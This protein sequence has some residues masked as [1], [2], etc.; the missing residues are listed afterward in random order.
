M[1]QR[2]SATTLVQLGA[3]QPG[4]WHVNAQVVDMVRKGAAPR[5]V[6][7]TDSQRQIRFDLNKTALLVIDMQNDFCHPDGW[8]SSIGV[9]VTPARRPIKPLQALLPVMRGHQVPVLWVNWGNRPDRLNLPPAV[10]HVYNP[11]GRG[12]G[13]GDPLPGSGAPVLQAGSW[14][15]QVVDE[16][17]IEAG[18]I[19]VNKFRMSGFKDTDLD[20]ILRNLNVTTLLFA[21]VNMDQCVL[22][23]LQDANS[24]GYDCIML[25]DCCATTSPAY[26]QAAAVYNTRQCFG[27]VA[28]STEL[29]TGLS[30]SRFE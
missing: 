23:T 21:G 7:V 8:L 3:S 6:S 22:Y 12:V 28:Q 15:A 10:L 20:S 5:P 18:D 14:A 26:C 2:V 16:L 9:D 1:T 11:D 27:F 30:D 25:E 24:A 19:R 4:A 17:P 13:L 29:L